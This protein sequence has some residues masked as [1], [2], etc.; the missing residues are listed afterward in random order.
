MGTNQTSRRGGKLSQD[1]MN[2]IAQESAVWKIMT[3][4][5]DRIEQP[6]PAEKAV[7]LKGLRSR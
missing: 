2:V 4:S 6:S 7:F 1:E 3:S 5:N